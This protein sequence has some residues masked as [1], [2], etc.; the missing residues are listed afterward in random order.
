MIVYLHGGYGCQFAIPQFAIPESFLKHPKF[1]EEFKK[2]VICDRYYDSTFEE[3]DYIDYDGSIGSL[4]GH[5]KSFFG[6]KVAVL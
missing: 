3:P 2:A 6:E 5:E 4:H 1:L